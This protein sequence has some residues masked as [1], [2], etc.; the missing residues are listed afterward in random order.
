MTDLPASDRIRPRPV[1]ARYLRRA[2]GFPVGVPTDEERH[3]AM[4]ILRTFTLPG[5]FPWT[6]LWDVDGL[7][8]EAQR[9]LDEADGL[10]PS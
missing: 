10:P 9:V 4:R 3:D 7:V 5:D 8:T 1:W 2:E 6:D